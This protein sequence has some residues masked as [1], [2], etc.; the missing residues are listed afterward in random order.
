MESRGAARMTRSA[1]LTAL[2][3]SD[4]PAVIAPLFLAFLRTGA[5]STPTTRTAGKRRLIAKPSDPPM[6]P[7]PTIV[8]VL[9]LDGSFFTGRILAPSGLE[10][11]ESQGKRLS[12]DCCLSVAASAMDP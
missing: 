5:L 3:R 6:R 1:L 2:E 9:N 11:R 7:T 12:G 8:M 4:S 10:N